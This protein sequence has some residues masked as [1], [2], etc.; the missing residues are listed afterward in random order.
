MEN[1]MKRGWV[2]LGVCILCSYG[3]DSVQHIFIKFPLTIWALISFFECF[4]VPP[5]M[6]CT[7]SLFLDH[8]F[9]KNTIHSS[10]SYIPLFVFWSVWKMRNRCIFDG[11][12]ASMLDIIRQVDYL[13]HMY[14][15]PKQK[16][17][18]RII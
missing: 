14:H 6:D 9:T 1:L 17:K 12:K 13:M 8:W 11:K 7:L 15:V 3:E 4:C 2:R 18:L 16:K 10:H 5:S